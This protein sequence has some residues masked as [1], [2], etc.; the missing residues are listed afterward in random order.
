METRQRSDSV[1][2]NWVQTYLKLKWSIE[3]RNHFQNELRLFKRQKSGTLTWFLYSYACTSR[4]IN[5]TSEPVCCR[6][7]WNKATL[8]APLPMH[9][10]KLTCNLEF[11]THALMT[12]WCNRF[13]PKSVKLR[14]SAKTIVQRNRLHHSCIVAS[15][16]ITP[17]I[18]VLYD[19][20]ANGGFGRVSQQTR[21]VSQQTGKISVHSGKV[22]QHSGKL[23]Q[24]SGKVSQQVGKV[25]QHQFAVKWQ[26]TI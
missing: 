21:K 3:L 11:R 25:S 15:E 6:S 2:P 24:Q 14:L 1:N 9:Y 10:S 13:R 22:S 16:Y 4:I 5:A 19:F 26:V 20:T 7:V 8:A 23:S 18:L 17:N 12:K